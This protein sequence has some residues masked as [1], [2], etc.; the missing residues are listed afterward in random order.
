MKEQTVEGK[1]QAGGISLNGYIELSWNTNRKDAE[2][3][4]MN[5]HG[6]ENKIF[7]VHK[8]F[9]FCHFGQFI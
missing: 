6:I 3:A 7:H 5:W 8:S 9:I 4:T 2:F 1:M